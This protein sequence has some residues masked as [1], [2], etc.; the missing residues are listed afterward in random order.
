[1]IYSNETS[2]SD[3]TVNE[4]DVVDPVVDDNNPD[5][6]NDINTNLVSSSSRSDMVAVNGGNNALH[7]NGVTEDS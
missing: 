5:A 2:G 1:M 4:H 3:E 7:N 6:I